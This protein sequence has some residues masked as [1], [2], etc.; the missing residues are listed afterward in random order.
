MVMGFILT[1]PI[2]RIAINRLGTMDLEHLFGVTRVVNRGNNQG[3]K[4]MR[5]L[6]KSSLV[7]QIVEHWGLTLKRRRQRKISRVYDGMLPGEELLD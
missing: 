3:E 2:P 5:R 6:V 7:T 4:F 1:L